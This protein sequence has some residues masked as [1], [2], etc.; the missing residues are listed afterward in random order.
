MPYLSAILVS[1]FLAVQIFA[2][3]TS[4]QPSIPNAFYAQVS[5]FA[6][7]Y[8]NSADVYV[9]Y[10][11]DQVLVVSNL[12]LNSSD[13]GKSYMYI[14]DG[15][16]GIAYRYLEAFDHCTF[17]I[18]PTYGGFPQLNKLENATY[19]RS[20]SFMGRSV[21][22][23]SYDMADN[24]DYTERLEI[25]YSTLD[26]TPAYL[27]ISGMYTSTP[28]IIN[29]FSNAAPSYSRFDLPYRCSMAKKMKMTKGKA[30]VNKP[31]FQPNIFN[32]PKHI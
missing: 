26:Y 3:K 23:Y 17:M 20:H 2:F 12:G 1:A 9:N 10:D 31:G 24:E 8:Q 27:M 15:E 16:L 4:A 30:K 29:S 21:E 22:V 13:A 11:Y 28:I 18:L 6:E 14:T 5:F 32:M 7:G 19:E 25:A